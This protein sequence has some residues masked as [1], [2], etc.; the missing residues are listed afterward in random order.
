MGN[1]VPLDTSSVSSFYQGV[2]LASFE[3]ICNAS[4]GDASGGHGYRRLS[5]RQKEAARFGAAVGAR[6]LPGKT[7]KKAMEN[8]H[9]SVKKLVLMSKM[10]N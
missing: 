4:K 2:P 5:K 9:V 8:H 1:V 3:V 6:H 10:V 7:A